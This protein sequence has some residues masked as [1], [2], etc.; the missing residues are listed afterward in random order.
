MSQ[1]IYV[2]LG[3]LPFINVCALGNVLKPLAYIVIR[4]EIVLISLTEQLVFSMS[5]AGAW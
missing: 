3:A 5:N 4:N 1:K 2:T